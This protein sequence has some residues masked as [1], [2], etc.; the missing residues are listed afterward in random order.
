MAPSI[1]F[2]TMP[3]HGGGKWNHLTPEDTCVWE[4]VLWAGFNQPK[5]ITLPSFLLPLP[6]SLPLSLPTHLS[7]CFLSC[8]PESLY[9]KGIKGCISSLIVSGVGQGIS[10]NLANAGVDLEAGA[11]PETRISVQ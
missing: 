4:P 9:A 5:P 10:V 11:T 6:F 1:D 8:F 3:G 2:L 7:P